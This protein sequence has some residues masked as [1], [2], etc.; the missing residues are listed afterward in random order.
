MAKEDSA[1]EPDSDAPEKWEDVK[2]EEC[3]DERTQT[4]EAL[5]ALLEQEALSAQTEKKVAC[6][7]R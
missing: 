2:L 1:S 6:H 3:E 4:T 7:C 5:Q